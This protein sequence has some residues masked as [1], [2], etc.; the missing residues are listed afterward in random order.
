MCWLTL[1][2][3][4]FVYR[5][6]RSVSSVVYSLGGISVLCAVS[7]TTRTRVSSTVTSVGYAGTLKKI[8]V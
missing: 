3:W 7:M 1:S 4:F 5:L 8:A 6:V 2:V